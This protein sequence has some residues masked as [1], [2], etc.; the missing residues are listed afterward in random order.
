MPSQ[1]TPRRF[2]VSSFASANTLVEEEHPVIQEPK[3]RKAHKRTKTTENIARIGKP[4]LLASWADADE[5]YL[6]TPPSAGIGPRLYPSPSESNRISE[7]EAR[8]R[9]TQMKPD[10][11]SERGRKS[12]LP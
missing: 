2:S 10:V 9:V 8:I 4:T 11:G 7:H 1:T 5:I 3:P 6:P 12:N